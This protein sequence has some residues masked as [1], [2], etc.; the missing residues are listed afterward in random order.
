MVVIY[1][2]A[3]QFW[4]PLPWIGDHI[5]EPHASPTFRWEGNVP[6]W[7]WPRSWH[8]PSPLRVWRQDLVVSHVRIQI[9][10]IESQ[11]QM[12]TELG[13]VPSE[14]TLYNC[15]AYD[16]ASTQTFYIKVRFLLELHYTIAV[17]IS[18]LPNRHFTSIYVCDNNCKYQT[19]C[20]LNKYIKINHIV[21]C[22]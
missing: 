18:V 1:T 17:Q 13:Q 2:G 10:G 4:G 9:T 7:S 14:T 21:G 15:G 3:P 12:W 11:C 5:V 6:D 19:V 20:S 16:C 8:S 22:R